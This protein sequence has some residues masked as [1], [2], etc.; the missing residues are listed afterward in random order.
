MQDVSNRE[1]GVWGLEM[2]KCGKEVYLYF[3]LNLS[4]NLKLF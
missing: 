2:W 1:T 3:L 4:V